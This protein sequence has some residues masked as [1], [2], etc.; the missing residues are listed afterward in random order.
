MPY[1]PEGIAELPW[2]S[3]LRGLESGHQH[4]GLRC[5]IQE[6]REAMSDEG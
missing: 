6:H 2:D 4:L 5:V 3:Q 1:L